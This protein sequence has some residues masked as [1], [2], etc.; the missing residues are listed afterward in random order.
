MARHSLSS[1]RLG[2]FSPR[3]TCPRPACNLYTHA[4]SHKHTLTHPHSHSHSHSHSLS[5]S[6]TLS[7]SHTLTAGRPA[8]SLSRAVPFRPDSVSQGR[9]APGCYPNR[10]SS[11]YKSDCE[12][13][14]GRATSDSWWTGCEAFRVGSQGYLAHKKT[15]TPLEPL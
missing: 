14:V 2:G 8:C 15:P 1:I 13:K 12:N 4:H 3:G 6:L 11:S 5:L 9:F 10:S 7:L